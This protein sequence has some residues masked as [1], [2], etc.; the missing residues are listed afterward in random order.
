MARREWN[1]LDS[2]KTY[3]ISAGNGWSLTMNADGTVTLAH[4][5]STARATTAASL[6]IEPDPG[7]GDRVP[8]AK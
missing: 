6:T 8:P 5:H 1:N 3:L 4:G 2:G 7:Q